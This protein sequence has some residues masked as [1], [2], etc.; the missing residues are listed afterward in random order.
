MPARSIIFLQCKFGCDLRALRC[1]MQKKVLIG[2]VL[3]QQVAQVDARIAVLKHCTG[4]YKLLL[5][6]FLFLPTLSAYSTYESSKAA[7]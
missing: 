7:T 6:L 3:Q 2:G 1:G 4:L 5:L